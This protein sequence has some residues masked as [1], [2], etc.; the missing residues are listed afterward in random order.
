MYEDRDYGLRR[1]LLS[2]G[3]KRRAN[4]E[5]QGSLSALTGRKEGIIV[6]VRAGSDGSAGGKRIRKVRPPEEPL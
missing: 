4:N 3:G 6:D 2:L 1:L 5:V